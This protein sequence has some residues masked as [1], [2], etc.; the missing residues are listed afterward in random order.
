[1][2]DKW[3]K[4]NQLVAENRTLWQQPTKTD[5]LTWHQK[6]DHVNTGMNVADLFPVDPFLLKIT[7]MP[8]A[9]HAGPC[10][11]GMVTAGNHSY[12]LHDFAEEA[13]SLPGKYNEVLRLQRNHV[14]TFSGWFF[15]RRPTDYTD[16][17]ETLGLKRYGGYENGIS[18]LIVPESHEILYTTR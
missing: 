17:F 1:M 18:L 6:L 5:I 13:P 15:V 9:T 4:P 3:P 7:D 10:I 8:I 2:I 14:Y 11:V 16:I 12:F